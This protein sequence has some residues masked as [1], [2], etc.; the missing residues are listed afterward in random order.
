MGL[1]ALA[2]LTASC[3]MLEDGGAD[4]GTVNRTVDTSVVGEWHLSSMTSEGN[5]DME[6]PDIYLRINQD[7]TF[8]L[9]QKSGTQALRHDKFTG[10]C[11]TRDGILYGKYSTGEAW[12]SK[13]EYS[14]TADGLTLRSFNLLEIN[15]YIKTAIPDDVVENAYEIYAKSQGSCTPIL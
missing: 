3:D 11:Y 15:I 8:E 4:N 10:T 5:S 2:G 1:A 6:M 13:W 9:Y 14:V 7:G 12:A